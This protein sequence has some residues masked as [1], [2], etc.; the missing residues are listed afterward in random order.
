[1]QVHLDVPHLWDPVRGL[2]T[3][4]IRRQPALLPDD[5]DI[6][7]TPAP[8][9]GTT[10]GGQVKVRDG[11]ALWRGATDRDVSVTVRMGRTWA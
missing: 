5:V 8:G 7:V 3:L 11:V 4:E 1:L 2:A 10:G 9:W 6:R